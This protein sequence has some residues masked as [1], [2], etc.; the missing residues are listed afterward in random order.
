VANFGDRLGKRYQA[1]SSVWMWSP[2]DRNMML[3][4][5]VT[6]H[7]ATDVEHIHIDGY[8]YIALSNEGDFGERCQPKHQTS[9]MYR[10]TADMCDGFAARVHDEL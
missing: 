4:T 8:D 7:G 6:S 1:Q 9:F 10:L 3:M 5:S 2:Q